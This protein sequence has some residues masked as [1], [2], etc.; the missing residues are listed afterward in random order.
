MSEADAASVDQS[1]KLGGRIQ[2]DGWINLART[3]IPG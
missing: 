3:L 2:R 1:L